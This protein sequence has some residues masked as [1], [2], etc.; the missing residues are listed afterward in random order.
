METRHIRKSRFFFPVEPVHEHQDLPSF[1]RCQNKG[2]EEVKNA[3]KR[4]RGQ[5][6]G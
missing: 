3:K 2:P 1:Q 4:I 6:L 5:L